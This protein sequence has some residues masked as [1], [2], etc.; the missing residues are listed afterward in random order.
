M[1]PLELPPG[2]VDVAGL[3]Q[4]LTR[5][6]A[7]RSARIVTVDGWQG[8]GKTTLAKNLASSLGLSRYELD[9]FLQEHR[10]GF[11]EYLDYLQL[12]A[13]L[14]E[15]FKK[16]RPILLDGICVLEVLQ[17]IGLRPDVKVY[18]RKISASGIWHH[19]LKLDPSKTAEQVIEEDRE[20]ARRW[21]EMEGTK[22]GES[23]EPL[24]YE[25]IRYHYKYLPHETAQFYFNRVEEVG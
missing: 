3:V 1:D 4:D 6:L 9:D 18:V 17:R 16:S 21:A 10:G 13:A 8:S 7:E 20:I 11:L 25:I 24:A 19:G 15:A 12:T 14:T 2:Y 22:F 23:G 5:S